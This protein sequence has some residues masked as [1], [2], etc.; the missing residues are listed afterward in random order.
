MVSKITNKKLSYQ[1]SYQTP[2][3]AARK[4]KDR[5]LPYLGNTYAPLRL[6]TSV[7]HATVEQ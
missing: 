6:L 2:K 7:V 4:G 1:K 3:R 5:V